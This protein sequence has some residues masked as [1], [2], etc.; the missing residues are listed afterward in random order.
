MACF[1][2]GS[3]PV[4][5]KTRRVEQRC[6]LNLSRAESSSRWCGVVVRRGG[7]QLRGSKRYFYINRRTRHSQ[8]TFPEEINSSKKSSWVQSQTD[9]SSST[10]RDVQ[11]VSSSSSAPKNLVQKCAATSS[12]LGSKDATDAS[13]VAQW[14][15]KTSPPPPPPGVD[16]PPPLP[17]I[18]PPKSPPPPPPDSTEKKRKHKEPEDM[19]IEDS[20]DSSSFLFVSNRTFS[21]D[22]RMQYLSMVEHS[23]LR[24]LTTFPN[25]SIF[26]TVS[27]TSASGIEGL[28]TNSKLSHSFS[29]PV[30]NSDV[31][32]MHWS[33]LPGYSQGT[34]MFTSANA[35]NQSAEGKNL[36]KYASSGNGVCSSQLETL[37]TTQPGYVGFKKDM[38]KPKIQ[39]PHGLKNKHMSSLVQK[40]AKIKNQQ[41]KE[42]EE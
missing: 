25:S 32:T 22:G 29:Y 3:S 19:D 4:P 18:S 2:T 11:T 14:I 9:A 31:N 17:P 7:C 20:N 8:W 36:D 5:L 1:V 24:S 6:T 40:W 13:A 15:L 27:S 42:D 38:K 21:E 12:M 34:L 10:E 28:G 30:S 39:P 26:N 35:N 23:S 41:C 16:S 33:N 37:N